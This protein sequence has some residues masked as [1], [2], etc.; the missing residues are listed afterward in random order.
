M[1]GEFDPSSIVTF[2]KPCHLGDALADLTRTCEGYPC[3]R[4]AAK[5]T[6]RQSYVQIP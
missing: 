1:S 5:L 2:F 3:E 4:S 6:R